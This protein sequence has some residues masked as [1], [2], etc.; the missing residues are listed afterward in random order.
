MTGVWQTNMATIR[1]LINGLFLEVKAQKPGFSPKTYDDSGAIYYGEKSGFFGLKHDFGYKYFRKNGFSYLGVKND[2]KKGRLSDNT[3]LL[4]NQFDKARLAVLKLY[5]IDTNANFMNSISQEQ[6]KLII[7]F[8]SALA[9]NKILVEP[10]LRKSQIGYIST[11]DQ[12]FAAFTISIVNATKKDLTIKVK[13]YAPLMS[14]LN[15]N[16]KGINLFDLKK[17]ANVNFSNVIEKITVLFETIELYNKVVTSAENKTIHDVSQIYDLTVKNVY[18]TDLMVIYTLSDEI[19]ISIINR[20]NIL[21]IKASKGYNDKQEFDFDENGICL[22]FSYLYENTPIPPVVTKSDPVPVPPGPTISSNAKQFVEDINNLPS[23]VAREKLQFLF[24]AYDELSEEDCNDSDVKDSYQILSSLY[25]EKE[26]PLPQSHRFVYASRA[27]LK[28]ISSLGTDLTDA[29]IKIKKSF[30]TI[31]SKNLGD[32]LKSK[33]LVY[34]DGYLKIR[35]KNGCKHRII[36]CFGDKIGKSPRDIY[37]FEYNTTHDFS[38][39]SDLNPAIQQYELWNFGKESKPVPPLSIKQEKISNSFNKPVICTGCAGSGKTLISVYLYCNLLEKKFDGNTNIDSKELVYVTY[40]ENAKNNALS[41][42]HEIV[43]FANAKTVYEFFH[44]IAEPDLVGL[45]Y[46]NEEQFFFWWHNEIHDYTF[47]SKINKL[48]SY[49]V[50]R[51]VYTFYRG[52]YKGSMYRWNI[53]IDKKSLTREQFFDLVKN[54]PLEESK[55]ELIWQ[56]CE[57]YQQYLIDKCMYDDNDL[58]RKVIRRIKRGLPANYEHIIIDEVQDLTEVQLDAVV[59]CSRDKR[60][61]YFFGDQNQSINPTLFDL[62]SIQMCL[63]KNDTSIQTE[64]IYELRNSFR[65]G[66]L[67]ANYINKLVGLKRDWIGSTG[68]DETESSNKN[69]EKNRWAG[70]GT[71]PQ[72]ADDILKRASNS[73]NAIIIV[74]DDSIKEELRKKYGDELAKRVTTIYDSKGLE[75]DYIVLYKMIKFN[76][77]K[78]LEMMNG[79]GKKSTLHRMVFNQ[80]YVGCTRATTCFSVI[81][82]DLDNNVEKVL[83][84]DLQNILPSNVG[85]YIEENTD[86]PSWLLEADRLFEQGVYELAK[87]AYEKA[88]VDITE[89]FKVELC[90][91]MSDKEKR[92]DVQ[93]ALKCKQNHN[94]REAGLIYRNSGNERLSKLMQLYQGVNISDSEA[95]DI[96]LNESLSDDDLAV[97]DGNGFLTKKSGNIENKMRTLLDSIKEK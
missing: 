42:L 18:A 77:D 2:I 11:Y 86:A 17:S 13:K 96:I 89:D 59:K 82:E 38:N 71:D 75:W 55:I 47:I 4:P 29:L 97:L 88:G 44:D 51:Y 43:D 30:N 5:D 79:G 3:F 90:D 32:Y 53:D 76:Q 26:E 28:A 40:N 69:P 50:E 25:E 8:E 57:R 23:D 72:V 61:L 64:N 34:I 91:I 20:K 60:K 24:D 62:N 6:K 80:Y 39:I 22:C 9:E 52:L 95:W 10:D 48:S 15:Q 78:Y 81:E 49:N 74:P 7:D 27:F 68:V 46:V 19:I 31:R 66:P 33:Q 83:I 84:G 56:I 58:A 16:E 35:V 1:E 65:F 14:E 94:Y 36:F 73:A 21:K 70:K 67:L 54:E 37:L 41:Q 45:K 12:N 92:K 63:E 87:S 85:L 93:F